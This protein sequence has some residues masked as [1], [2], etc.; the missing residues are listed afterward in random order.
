[1]WL[2]QWYFFFLALKKII[3]KLTLTV[4]SSFILICASLEKISRVF[5]FPPIIPKGR[6]RGV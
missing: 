4:R 5:F 6:L 2:V 3:L 1:M